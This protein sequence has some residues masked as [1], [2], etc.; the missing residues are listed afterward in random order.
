M[1]Q[2]A[3]LVVVLGIFLGTLSL[4]RARTSGQPIE[5]RASVKDVS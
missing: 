4:N 2:L 1:G 5:G 3:I